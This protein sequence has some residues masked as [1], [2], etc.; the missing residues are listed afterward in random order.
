MITDFHWKE[1]EAANRELA[2]RLQKLR[3]VRASRDR[4]GLQ[5][6]EMAYLQALQCVY[7]AAEEAVTE[8]GFKNAKGNL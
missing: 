6:A 8:R 3:K 7:T 4:E 5:R 2:F 1:L